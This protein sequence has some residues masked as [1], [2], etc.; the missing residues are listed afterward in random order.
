MSSGHLALTLPAFEAQKCQGL[1][2]AVPTPIAR[3]LNTTIGQGS[4]QVGLSSQVLESQRPRL[5][6]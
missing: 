6:P 4:C 2:L 1:A 3:K 5:Q